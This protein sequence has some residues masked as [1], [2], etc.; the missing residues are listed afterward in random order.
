MRGFPIWAIGIGVV[1]LIAAIWALARSGGPQP[2]DIE[3][4]G[5]PGI[6][7]DQEV[8]DYGAVKLGEKPIR[9]QVRVTNVGDHK[10]RFT[11]TPYVEVLE[12]C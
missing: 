4:T 2:A 7:V 12:G 1:L 3:V 10:L 8:F 5:A 6:R 9:T 11:K